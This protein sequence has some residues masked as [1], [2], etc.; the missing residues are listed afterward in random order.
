MARADSKTEI[1]GP[2]PPG[3]RYDISL[4]SKV[5][6]YGVKES[7]CVVRNPLCD[8]TEAGPRRVFYFE[9]L[10]ISSGASVKLS[11]LPD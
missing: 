2:L 5:S 3:I 10:L 11:P 1:S 9:G 6:L 8:C 7:L 4:R